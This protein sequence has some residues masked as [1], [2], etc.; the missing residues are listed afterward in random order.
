M[1]LYL[2]D[3]FKWVQVKYE[4]EEGETKQETLHGMNDRIFQHENEHMNGYIFKDLVSDFK[5][6]R[7]NEK[8]KKEIN[9]ILKRQ[10]NGKTFTKKYIHVNQHKIRSNLKH[11]KN[12]FLDYN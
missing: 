3:E 9:K 11:G 1:S 5:W 12:E 7:A 6:K 4:D 8:A 10:K 2:L